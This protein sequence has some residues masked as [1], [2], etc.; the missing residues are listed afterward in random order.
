MK[1]EKHLGILLSIFSLFAYY[2]ASLPNSFF[3]GSLAELFS[4]V[5]IRRIPKGLQ[6]EYGF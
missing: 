2:L 4:I 3:I 6:E 5:N 1:F